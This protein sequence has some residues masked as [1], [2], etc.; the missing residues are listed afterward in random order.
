[1]KIITSTIALSLIASFAF[2]QTFN[3]VKMDSLM[4]VLEQNNRAMGSICITKDGKEEYRR[5]IGFS[6]INGPDKKHADIHSKY[7]IG[8][9]SK[10]FTATLIMQLIEEK[11]LNMDTKLD[12]FFPEIP[13]AGKITISHL[14][15]HRSG[16]HNFTDDEAYG[17]YMQQAKTQKEL[18]DIIAKAGSD[19]E[20]DSKAEY[21]NSN[22]VLLG[23]IVEKLRGKPYA[24][25]LQKK[26]A[27]KAD[28]KD[29]YYGAKISAAKNESASFQLTTEWNLFPET[30]MSIPGG[31]GAIV[32]TPT[33][34]DKF[35][36]ALFNGKLISKSALNQMMVFK[37][38]YGR[39]IFEIPFGDKKFYGHG[40]SIDGFNSMLGYN[41]EDKV[42]FAYC[43]N[44]QN[45]PINDI[46]IG[47]LS[48]YYNKDYS[49]PTFYS[50]ELPDS[51]LEAYTGVYS[52]KDIPLK[53]TITKEGK[54]LMA[55]ATGQS[56]FPLE[57]RG[58]NTFKFDAAGITMEF[59]LFKKEMTLMQGAG[60]YLFTKE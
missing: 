59:N 17:T 54:T 26:I 1:M 46:V 21:S 43:S 57:L 14:L 38:G 20:P 53:I 11:K 22:F 40:G 48:I 36:T 37:D 33:D 34:L 32:S 31:A 25:V 60:K 7:R 30:D 10:M 28:L 55:Q 44:G 13:N 16:I 9:I 19:F 24:E 39:G 41:P 15:S 51:T 4:T 18:L 27:A 23:F 8:S 12:K 45:Y 3:K 29:T 58:K 47:A 5:A 42:A 52:S 56:A 2:G 6:A 35:I 50:L 49:L